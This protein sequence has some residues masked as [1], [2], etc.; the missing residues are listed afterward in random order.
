MN[1]LFGLLNVIHARAARALAEMAFE[2][3]KRGGFSD[4]VN[5]DRPI[6]AILGVTHNA[7]LIGTSFR[8][9]SEPDALHAPGNDIPSCI[10]HSVF[11]PGF[12]DGS[13]L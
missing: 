10:F 1:W 7:E 3:R 5:F 4:G 11:L 8:K 13:G 6:S 12:T 2:L 9:E